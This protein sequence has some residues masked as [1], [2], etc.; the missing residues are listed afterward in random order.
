MNGE[1]RPPEAPQGKSNIPN[2]N[3]IK[4]LL[5]IIFGLA[6]MVWAYKIIFNMA[7]FVV[8]GMLIYYGLVI[9]KIKQVT[10]LIDQMV[11]KVKRI[12]T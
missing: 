9:L 2:L 7:L 5:A 11:A 3:V 4:G 10:D 8:G 1:N 12:F 6:F